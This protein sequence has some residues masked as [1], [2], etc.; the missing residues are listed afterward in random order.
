M[1]VAMPTLVWPNKRGVDVQILVLPYGSLFALTAGLGV[2]GQS[3]S[4]PIFIAG[5]IGLGYL[6]WRAGPGRHV[7]MA[8]WLFAFSPLL[9]RVVDQGCGYD[10]SG[11]MLAGPLLALMVPCV[12][13]R[14]LRQGA[15]TYYSPHILFAG[16]IGYAVLIS[17]FGGAFA[18]LPGPLLKTVAPLLYGVWVQERVAQGHDVMQP[19]ARAFAWVTP[20]MG[21]Y[22]M[23]QYSNPPEWDRLWMILSGMDSIGMPS[24]YQVRAFS[25]MNSPGSYATFA[26]CGLMLFGFCSRRWWAALLALPVGIGLCLSLYRTSWLAL[27]FGVLFCVI[28]PATRRRSVLVG[29]TLFG[30]AVLALGST[31][32]GDVLSQRFD[33]LGALSNDG[34]LAARIAEFAT[35]YARAGDFAFGDG[36]AAINQPDNPIGPLDGTMMQVFVGMGLFVGSICISALLWALRRALVHISL[37]SGAEMVVAAAVVLGEI[38]QLPFASITDGELGFLFWTMVGIASAQQAAG[39]SAEIGLPQTHAHKAIFV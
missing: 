25:T 1:S 19:L 13:L 3:A 34:S 33:S 16:C 8:T 30:A 9:R 15:T 2:I 36:L 4:R 12:D 31:E 20:I 11:I 6:G 22:A 14:R 18:A 38:V 39:F 27:L 5:C 32:F 21:L 26:A 10:P 29:L 37:L 17:A 24:P 7:Q 28:Y 23:W 35:F